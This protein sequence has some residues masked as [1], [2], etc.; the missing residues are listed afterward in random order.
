VSVDDDLLALIGALNECTGR[1]GDTLGRISA[2]ILAAGHVNW[3]DPLWDEYDDAVSAE[4]AA[5]ERVRGFRR[6]HRI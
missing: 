6:D 2:V 3:D 5:K 4:E 1:R